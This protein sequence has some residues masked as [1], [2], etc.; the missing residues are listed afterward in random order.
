MPAPRGGHGVRQPQDA[1]PLPARSGPLCP[2]LCSPGQLLHLFSLPCGSSKLC[3]LAAIR[4][5]LG[6]E[7]RPVSVRGALFTWNSRP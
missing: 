7:R 5:T 2:F 3:P 1:D 6:R 4:V